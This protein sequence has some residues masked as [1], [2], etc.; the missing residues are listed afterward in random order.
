MWAESKR[1]TGGRGGVGEWWGVFWVR[2]ESG[3]L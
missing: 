3:T 1:L 2:G